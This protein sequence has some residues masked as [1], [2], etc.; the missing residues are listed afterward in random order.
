[1]RYSTNTEYYY[2]CDCDCGKKDHRVKG[3]ELLSG[4]FTSCGNWCGA[5]QITIF[6]ETK[7]RANWLR[8]PRCRVSGG[9]LDFRLKAGWDPATALTTPPKQAGHRHQEGYTLTTIPIGMQFGKLTVR[10]PHQRVKYPSGNNE[11]FYSCDCACGTTHY[12]AN[13]NR[14]L[15]GSL[16]FCG[17]QRGKRHPPLE[18]DEK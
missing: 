11:Y 13:A 6:N 3:S 15:S 12:L 7:T 9:V 4:K 16:T 8:D 17:C 5:H 14:L 1:V 2:L 10:S 18:S